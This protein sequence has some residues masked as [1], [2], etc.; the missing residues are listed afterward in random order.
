VTFSVQVLSSR[1]GR[2]TEEFTAQVRP[3]NVDR[4][5]IGQLANSWSGD[6]TRLGIMTAMTP[7]APP[8]RRIGTE[9]HVWDRAT[10]KRV[11]GLQLDT[12]PVDFELL[13]NG[14]PMVI[15]ST[16]STLAL[17]DV[18]TGRLVRKLDTPEPVA[19]PLV[20]SADGRRMAAVTNGRS[21]VVWDIRT[22][23]Q[24]I[25]FAQ[26]SATIAN[27]NFSP[28]GTRLVSVSNDG[29]VQLWDMEHGRA[30]IPLRTSGDPVY[31]RA[32]EY[33][34][35]RTGSE[36]VPS[37][38]THTVGFSPEGEEIHLSVITVDENGISG[39]TIAWSGAPR[40]RNTAT[41][42]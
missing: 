7:V 33:R 42:P 10:G 6:G 25:T 12:S 3:L 20:Y 26:Q 27:M 11:G 9:V 30:L 38:T 32:F 21:I 28:D 1:Q 35:R 24:E 36:A 16:G 34:G 8:Y 15:L 31:E 19:G 13:P 39:R 29:N 41:N 23:R 22:G 5:I 40:G 2:E 18:D 14:K 37:V 17:H 4:A